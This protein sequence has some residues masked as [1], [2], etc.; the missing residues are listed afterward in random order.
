[1][2]KSEATQGGMGGPQGPLYLA[3]AVKFY[4]DAWAFAVLA[5]LTPGLSQTFSLVGCS[6]PAAQRWKDLS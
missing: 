2:N 6:G 3:S 4:P 1:M 5:E